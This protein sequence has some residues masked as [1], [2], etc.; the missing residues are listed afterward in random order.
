MLY[1]KREDAGNDFL[2]DAR[3]LFTAGAALLAGAAGAGSGQSPLR[4]GTTAAAAAS[5]AALAG[6]SLAQATEKVECG[7]SHDKRND[8]FFHRCFL[9]LNSVCFL[10]REQIL[11]QLKIIFKIKL[12]HL[13]LAPNLFYV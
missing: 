11:Q 1:R 7:H 4:H 8:D 6:K 9:R 12:S 3:N 2:A 5:T 13:V 10:L